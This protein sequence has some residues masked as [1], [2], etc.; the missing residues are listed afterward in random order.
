VS[1]VDGVAEID[2]LTLASGA[3]CG[4]VGRQSCHLTADV[5]VP[6]LPVT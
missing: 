4:W 2:S 5:S 3:K 6:P 1:A